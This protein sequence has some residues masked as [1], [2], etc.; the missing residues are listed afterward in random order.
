[1]GKKFGASVALGCCLAFAIVAVCSV[2]NNRDVFAQVMGTG[3]YCNEQ[4]LPAAGC[5]GTSTSC[6]GLCLTSCN[7]AYQYDGSRSCQG[8]Y[9]GSKCTNTG[10]LHDCATEYVCW[11]DVPNCETLSGPYGVSSVNPC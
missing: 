4:C 10:V 2:T 6:T 3:T 1:M 8:P 7:D 11:C 9:Q 5:Q